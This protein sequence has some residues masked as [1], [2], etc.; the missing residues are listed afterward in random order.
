MFDFL[1]LKPKEDRFQSW[2][3]SNLQYLCHSAF[4]NMLETD[5]IEMFLNYRKEYYKQFAEWNKFKQA[6]PN[7]SPSEEPGGRFDIAQDHKFFTKNLIRIEYDLADRY[8]EHIERTLLRYST[9]RG[10]VNNL[11]KCYDIFRYYA[12]ELN[13]DVVDY[14]DSEIKERFREYL[15]EN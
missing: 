7:M 2:E 9:P 15:N 6:H 10:K 5:S 13:A 4:D 8:I 11:N 3:L 1:R 12:P 14:L